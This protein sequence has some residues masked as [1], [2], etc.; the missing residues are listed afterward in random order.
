[1]FDGIDL[2]ALRA[3]SNPET[4]AVNRPGSRGDHLQLL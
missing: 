3:V 4:G 2:V 1:L